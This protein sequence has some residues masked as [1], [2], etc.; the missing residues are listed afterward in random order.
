MAEAEIKALDSVT[1]V[2][3]V[4]RSADFQVVVVLSKEVVDLKEVVV[5]LKEVVADLKE[6]V[7]LNQEVVEAVEA[8]ELNEEI[9]TTPIRLQAVLP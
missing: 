2:A 8:V 4:E 9:G 6:E 7:V 3:G 1:A 5:D